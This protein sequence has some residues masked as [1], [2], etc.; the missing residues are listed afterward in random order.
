MCGAELDVEK[1]IVALLGDGEDELTM[2]V[3]I[4][5][6]SKNKVVKSFNEPVA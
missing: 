5:G 2:Y 4:I 3:V 1:I 6:L